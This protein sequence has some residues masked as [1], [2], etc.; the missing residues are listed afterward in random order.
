MKEMDSGQMWPSSPFS[1]SLVAIW[2]PET[3][4]SWQLLHFLASWVASFSSY[5]LRYPTHSRCSVNVCQVER[6]TNGSLKGEA[7]ILG[8]SEM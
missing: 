4:G 2:L 6:L 8:N 1:L 7:F 3:E 5:L